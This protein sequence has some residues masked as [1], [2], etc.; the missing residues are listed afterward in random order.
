LVIG[1]I[2]LLQDVTASNYDNLT[3][4]HMSNITVTTAHKKASVFTSRF[5]VAAS[6]GDI[7][8]PL[9]SRNVPGLSYQL[10]TSRHCKSQSQSYF[11]TGGLPPISSSWRQP[12]EAHDQDYLSQLNSCDNSPYVTSFLTRRTASLSLSLIL[13]PTVS[14]SVCLGIKHP[15]GAYDQIFITV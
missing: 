11:T 4:T 6:T 10:L 2:E 8:L 7:P 9:G 13:R 3:E 15:S 5:L 14:R 1:F 12:L